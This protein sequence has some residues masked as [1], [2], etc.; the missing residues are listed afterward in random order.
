MYGRSVAP[1]FSTI[2][3]IRKHKRII[4]IYLRILY[5]MLV[6][7]LGN[8]VFNISMATCQNLTF[9]KNDIFTEN[10]FD[11]I[12]Y[13]VSMACTQILMQSLPK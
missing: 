12:L 7:S 6:N 13:K 4:W 11:T 10:I 1:Y 9:N 5:S 3:K 2:Y 8:F